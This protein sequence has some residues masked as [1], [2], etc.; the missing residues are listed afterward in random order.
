[1]AGLVGLVPSIGLAQAPVV[2]VLAGQSPAPAPHP[3]AQPAAAAPVKTLTVGECTAI[4]IENQPGMK[5]ALESLHAAEQGRQVL[6]HL[7]LLA[8][9]ARP[10]LS[11][12]KKQADRGIDVAT[13]A[14]Q[15][16]RDEIVYDVGYLYFTY[17]YAHQQETIVSDLVAQLTQIRKIIEDLLNTPDPGQ[18]TRLTL[19]QVVDGLGQ[20]K[21]LQSQAKWGKEIALAALKEVMGVD[22]GFEFVPKDV[23]LPLMRGTTTREQVVELAMT[24]RPEMAMAA[25]GV[26]AFRLETESQSKLRFRLQTQTLASGADLHATQI[27]APLRNGEYRP[28]AIEPEMPLTLLGSREERVRRACTISLRQDAVYE[29]I[30]NLVR[31][32]AT[33]A[34]LTWRQDG[35]TLDVAKERFDNAAKILDLAKKNPPADKEKLIS[36]LVTSG[37]AQSDYLTAAHAYVK[38][39]LTLERVTAGGVRPAF[40]GK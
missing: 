27:P 39:L 11:L 31:L 2:P 34:Y 17:V 10:D 20:V 8:N 9:V 28:G 22:G 26:D 6:D 12:R 40:P 36:Y 3:L 16:T 23:E 35:D 19:Y 1:V 13:A 7:P 25:G 33:K 32:E 37:K 4:A 24:R 18:V 38:S 21:T 29:K 5:A 30:V 14:V 15:K